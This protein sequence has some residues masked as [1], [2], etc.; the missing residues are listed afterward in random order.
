MEFTNVT[1]HIIVKSQQRKPGFIA[2]VPA[3]LITGNHFVTSTVS[4]GSAADAVNLIKNPSLQL[5]LGDPS[6]FSRSVWRTEGNW[7]FPAG[8]TGG[9][10]AS[11]TI[12]GYAP[13]DRQLLQ[14]ETATTPPPSKLP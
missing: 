12:Q 7:T 4:R 5:G 13:G 14:T 8:R 6:C 11:V 3:V 10:P 1:G 2:A 9:R